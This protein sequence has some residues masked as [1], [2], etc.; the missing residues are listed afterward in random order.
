MHRRR[1]LA[2]GSALLTGAGCQSQSESSVT[3]VPEP[4]VEST[5]TDG[6]TQVDVAAVA[7]QPGVVGPN[8]PDSIGVFDAD[9]QHLLLTVTVTDGP[10]PDASAF[11]F[12]FDGE[13]HSPEELPNGLYRGEWG[14]G[15]GDGQGPLVFD[16]PEQG[17]PADARLTWPGGA[18]TPPEAVRKRLADP[19]PSF[20]VSL[21]GPDAVTA[22]ADPTISVTVR[23]AGETT[24]RVA[25]A[26]NRTGPRVAYAPVERIV[27]ELAPG[28]KMTG[29]R[30]AE[31]PN[32]SDAEDRETIYRLDAPG[33]ENDAIHRIQQATAA[34]ETSTETA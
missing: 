15:Y 4:T 8:T 32:A 2:L 27:A 6:A 19:L 3:P 13:A 21:D 22:E 29:K 1:F 7:V 9:G 31:N 16:L 28:E 23:N 34:T 25:L 12:R 14:V 30:D 5:A 18:W 20:D 33:S 24:G 17:D 11:R 10:T 26:L